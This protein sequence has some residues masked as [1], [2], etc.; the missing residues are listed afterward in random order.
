M[1]E[2]ELAAAAVR[3]GAG[4]GTGGG[5]DGMRQHVR[6]S[7]VA[8]PLRPRC[9]PRSV[10]QR[11]ELTRDGGDAGASTALCSLSFVCLDPVL[12]KANLYM[13]LTQALYFST[14]G[15]SDYFCAHLLP[16]PL[17]F[18]PMPWLPLLGLPCRAAEVVC[19]SP[20]IPSDALAAA[21]SAAAQSYDWLCRHGGRGVCAGRSSVQLHILHDIH[22]RCGRHLLPGWRGAV[23]ADYVNLELQAGILGHVSSQRWDPCCLLVFFDGLSLRAGR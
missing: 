23:P 8:V 20:L 18:L 7:V 3:H 2:A 1:A 6:G 4:D 10:P 5:W 15:A 22:E 9:E 17:L 19:A 21:A 13:F 12:A 11:P 14:S 16:S